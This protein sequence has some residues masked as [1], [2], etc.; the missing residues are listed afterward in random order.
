MNNKA[1]D[2]SWMDENEPG[3]RNALTCHI[4]I[5]IESEDTFRDI[6]AKAAWALRTSAAQVEAGNY[7]DGHHPIKTLNGEKVGEIY[8]DYSGTEEC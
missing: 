2:T 8:I 4:E 5:D 1:T 7:E 6:L 3:C